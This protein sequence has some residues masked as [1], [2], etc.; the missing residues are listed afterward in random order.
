MDN[1]EWIQVEVVNKNGIS[2]ISK[3]TYYG[4]W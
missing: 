1:I 2:W 4:M 3:N